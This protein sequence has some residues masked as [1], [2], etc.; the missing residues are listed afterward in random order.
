MQ[1]FSSNYVS[2]HN[3]YIININMKSENCVEDEFLRTYNVLQ[4][5]LQR[6]TPTKPSKYL[7]SKYENYSIDPDIRYL[8]Q[9]E[10]KWNGVIKG[11]GNNNPA[12]LFYE[13]ILPK[14]LNGEYDFVSKQ[15]IFPLARTFSAQ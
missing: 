8:S 12:K 4:N 10:C 15:V 9:D 6:G 1:K 5:I 11:Y 7:L 14:V 13:S 2:Y 3:N